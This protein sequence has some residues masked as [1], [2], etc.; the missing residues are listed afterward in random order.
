MKKTFSDFYNLASI[1]LA[2]QGKSEAPC[3]DGRSYGT[4]TKQFR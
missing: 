3:H 2:A 4:S 1:F